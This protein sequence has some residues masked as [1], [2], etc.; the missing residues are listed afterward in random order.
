MEVLSCRVFTAFCLSLLRKASDF[1]CFGV[2]QIGLLKDGACRSS[3]CF[4]LQRQW[5]GWDRHF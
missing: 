4:R 3:P 2:F 5:L 1:V